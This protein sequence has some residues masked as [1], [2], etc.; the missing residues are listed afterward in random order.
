MCVEQM[1]NKS[2]K[3]AQNVEQM[4]CRKSKTEIRS[5][6]RRGAIMGGGQEITDRFFGRGGGGRRLLT[7]FLA[8]GGAI[9]AQFLVGGIWPPFAHHLFDIC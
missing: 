2:A 5:F 4:K 3:V 7:D 9:L 8:G 6:R 1:L